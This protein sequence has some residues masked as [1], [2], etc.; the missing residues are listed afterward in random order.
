MMR[1]AA[2][3][4]RIIGYA[5]AAVGRCDHSYSVDTEQRYVEAING[6]VARFTLECIYCDEQ[7][8][9]DERPQP[10]AVGGEQ[11]G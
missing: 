2:V 6:H 1:G 8:V 10:L 5:K 7:I 4:N 3:L 9:V 11:D